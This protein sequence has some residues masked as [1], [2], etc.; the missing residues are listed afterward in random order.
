MRCS[1]I[2]YYA[3]MNAGKTTQL[4][5]CNHIYIE[6]GFQTLIIKPRI[7]TRDGVHFNW[8]TI[9]SR[10]LDEGSMCLYIEK[11]KAEDLIRD[12]KFDILFVDEAQFFRRSDILELSRLVD[13]YDKQVYVYGLKSDFRGILFEGSAALL[14]LS[15]EIKEIEQICDC[16][17][18]ANINL[19]RRDGKVASTGEIFEIEKGETSYESL[20]R[21]CYKD[22]GGILG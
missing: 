4:L 18:K 7:D 10:I 2:F 14:G 11:V 20:C 3:V 15:D 13:E 9:R 12:Y 17:R 21:K 8:G 16:G 5:Q 6:K 1:L 22:K 19:R